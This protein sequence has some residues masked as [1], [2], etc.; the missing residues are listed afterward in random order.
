[1]NQRRGPS[2]SGSRTA[3]RPSVRGP[4]V[5]LVVGL[6]LAACFIPASSTSARPVVYL[7]TATFGTV[8]SIVGARRMV[9]AQ[10]RIW[11]AFAFG[12]GSFLAGDAYVELHVATGA[13]VPQTSLADIGYLA[14]YPALALGT[15]WMIR[16]RWRGQDRPAFLDAMIVASGLTVVGGVLLVGPAAAEG[17]VSLLAQAVA[18]S[19][20]AFDLLLLALAVRLVTGGLV[21]SPAMWGMLAG[22]AL[23]LLADLFYV[24]RALTGV[25]YPSWVDAVYLVSYVLYGFA[26]VHPSAPALS[27]PAATRGSTSSWGRMAWLGVALVLAPVT[28]QLAHLLDYEHG[29]WMALLGGFVVAGLVV[30]RLADLV[31]DL[32]VKAVQL[33]A[34]AR[35]DG[36][37]G[38]ANRLTWEHELSRACAI[39]REA[40]TDLTV[41]ILDFDHFK[42]YNDEHGH[43]AGDQVLKATAATWAATLPEQGFVAR[44]GGEEFA[45]LLPGLAGADAVRVLDRLRTAVTHGQTCSI[46]TATW[47]APESPASLVARADQ[48]LYHAKREGRNRISVH[49]GHAF[50]VASVATPDPAPERISAVFQPIVDLHSHAVLAHEALSRFEG[51]SPQE[52]FGSALREGTAPALEARA[53]RA[54]LEAWPGGSLLALNLSPTALASSAVEEVLPQDMSGL[55]IELTETDLAECS[56]AVMLT[57]DGLR[58]RG[59]L[60]AVDDFGTGFSNVHRI[61]MLRPD[62]IKLDMSLVRKIDADPRLHGAV[63]ATLV[64]A[65]HTGSRVIAEGIETQAERDCLVGLGVQ[66]GQGFL[67]GR[68]APEPVPSSSS[69][70]RRSGDV[71]SPLPRRG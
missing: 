69:P 11:W 58:V 44:F 47:Q 9:G 38:I 70:D 61:A 18:G 20:P 54:A 23:L 3:P 49:D 66:L 43:L 32:Q 25:P 10:R 48:A 36:L 50:T 27:E 64:L 2:P 41:A 42:A 5:A 68:P 13:A 19:Y 63:A 12:Q 35:R 57:I 53:V 67:I 71:T 31:R 37:T 46:G 55:I 15:L 7:A 62:L 26:A 28:G 51:R 52:A 16:G 21:R 34:L 8:L 24:S 33:A 29:E 45:V 59:A 14:C 17:G 4:Y 39:A 60:I 6:A 65:Q 30:V 56:D 22:C 1:M 40:Q